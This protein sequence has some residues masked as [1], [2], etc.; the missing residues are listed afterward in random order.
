MLMRRSTNGELARGLSRRRRSAIALGGLIKLCESNSVGRPGH[1]NSQRVLEDYRLQR[2]ICRSLIEALKLSMMRKQT[3]RR[4]C[5]REITA[6]QE[7]SQDAPRPSCVRDIGGV[8]RGGDDDGPDGGVGRK[9]VRAAED[10]RCGQ[11]VNDKVAAAS[12]KRKRS[13]TVEP[14][15]VALALP[16]NSSACDTAVDGASARGAAHHGGRK[17]RGHGRQRARCWRRRRRECT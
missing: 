17:R 2:A 10:R 16:P 9:H 11:V 14:G 12:A 5:R 13:T 7:S 8:A 1:M 15:A 4:Q 6:V 3:E